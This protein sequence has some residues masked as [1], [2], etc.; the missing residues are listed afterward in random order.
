M[1]RSTEGEP[2]RIDNGG[3]AMKRKQR[4]IR[5]VTAMLALL[6]C[7]IGLAYGSTRALA[8]PPEAFRAGGEGGGGGRNR[9][10]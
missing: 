1:R 10:G 8:S 3:F 9:V 7:V 5:I 6:A 4:I 2:F